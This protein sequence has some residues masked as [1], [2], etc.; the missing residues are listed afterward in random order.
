MNASRAAL[1]S[2]AGFLVLVSCAVPT[3]SDADLIAAAVKGTIEARASLPPMTVTPTPSQS[4]IPR[5]TPTSTSTLT[6]T[7]MLTPTLPPAMA[8]VSLATNCRTGPGSAYPYVFSLQP[9]Q[10]ARVTARSTVE[11]YWYIANPDESDEYCW[12]WGEYATVEGDASILPALTAEP[13][14]IPRLDF[15]MYRHSFSECGSTRVVFTVMNKSAT[16]FRSARLHVEDLST[17]S[18]L[19]GPRKELHPFSDNPSSCPRDKDNFFPPGAVAYILIPISS[20]EAGNDA[21][22]NIKLCTE[23]DGGGDCA[24]KTAYFRLPDE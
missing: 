7:A 17:F 19:H 16:T 8:S 15:T 2:L 3:P 24:T 21:I 10:V 5:Q 22:A 13:S 18:D 4:P 12:L 23:D 6:P 14:P 20:F 1:L 9:G 11:D